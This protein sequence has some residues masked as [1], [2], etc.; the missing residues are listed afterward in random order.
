[1]LIDDYGLIIRLLKFRRH[2][3]QPTYTMI[4]LNYSIIMKT[5]I[6]VRCEILSKKGYT[7]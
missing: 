1:M 3:E 5:L 6:A 4:I 2:Q 7:L